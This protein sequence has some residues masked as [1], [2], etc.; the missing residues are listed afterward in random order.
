MVPHVLVADNGIN[1]LEANSLFSWLP[2][3]S[4]SPNARMG[5]AF[6]PMEG[7]NDGTITFWKEWQFIQNITKE[8]SLLVSN[9]LDVLQIK[10][11]LFRRKPIR[12]NPSQKQWLLNMKSNLYDPE[13]NMR[14]TWYYQACGIISWKHA[15]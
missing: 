13:E 6:K 8:G 4:R 7:E 11:K 15:T 3:P 2:H 10:I 12:L 5:L 14:S 9:P 1:S